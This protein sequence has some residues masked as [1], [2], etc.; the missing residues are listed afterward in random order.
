MDSFFFHLNSL[1]FS[2][3][4]KI[5]KKSFFLIEALDWCCMCYVYVYMTF[6]SIE[7]EGKMKSRGVFIKQYYIRVSSALHFLFKKILIQLKYVY[8][9][10]FS[11]T[12]NIFN[13]YY[14]FCSITFEYVSMHEGH[15]LTVDS[16]Q[17]IDFINI[18]FQVKYI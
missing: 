3:F 9:I 10:T 4:Y 11:N 1:D 13:F 16:V 2:Y 15:S 12:W 7:K 8:S 17:W 18:F 14:K 6:F 5:K